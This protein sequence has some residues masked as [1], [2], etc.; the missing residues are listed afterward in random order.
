[1]YVALSRAAPTVAGKENA[2]LMIPRSQVGVLAR[3]NL[4][5]L[6]IFDH[7][8]PFGIIAAAAKCDQIRSTDGSLG[9]QRTPSSRYATYWSRC[10]T[11]S[12]APLLPSAR[13]ARPRLRLRYG[14]LPP[15][16]K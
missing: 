6:G 10:A 15:L 5:L 11:R 3:L 8:R 9:F 16:Q 14:L 13:K 2:R 7:R 1:M 4:R 12:A